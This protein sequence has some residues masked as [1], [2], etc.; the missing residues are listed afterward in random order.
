MLKKGLPLQRQDISPVHHLCYH[1]VIRSPSPIRGGR[2]VRGGVRPCRRGRLS[3][4]G[5]R[6][7]GGGGI[8]TVRGG[9]EDVAVRG[10]RCNINNNSG[11]GY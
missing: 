2:P 3:R 8:R 5:G 4:G 9:G 7:I 10:Q 11:H 6:T 1:F